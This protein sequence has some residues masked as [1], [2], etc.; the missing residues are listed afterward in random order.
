MKVLVTDVLKNGGKIGI[1]YA[2]AT[3]MGGI[4]PGVFAIAQD[5]QLFLCHMGGGC[6]LYNPSSSPA[7]AGILAETFHVPLSAS[8]DFAL[9][10][11]R[12]VLD[13]LPVN[14][15]IDMPTNVM[16]QMLSSEA[17]L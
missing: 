5:G 9:A 7:L 4:I 16:Q 2:I 15:A 3:I 12:T 6:R 11:C 8:D 14:T 17:V 1:D 10:V 13:S